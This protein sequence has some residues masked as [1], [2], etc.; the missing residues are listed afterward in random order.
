[1]LFMDNKILNRLLTLKE[2]FYNHKRL[3]SYQEM[4]SLWELS[5]KNAVSKVVHKL[6]ELGYLTQ[7]AVRQISP[8]EMF[9]SLNLYGQVP[10]GFPVPTPDESADLLSLESYLVEHPTRT[11][12]L[13]VSGDSLK[14]L[15]IM[16]GDLVIVERASEAKNGQVVLAYVDEEWTLKILIK[17]GRDVHLMPANKKYSAII[18]QNSLTI[19]GIVT[20]VVRKYIQ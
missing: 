2:F 9:F 13:K 1:M 10:A 5:S 16:P 17:E 19:H 8:A 11:F 12:L 15:G 14:D 3:P 18:P 7:D 6:I 4:L 20:G